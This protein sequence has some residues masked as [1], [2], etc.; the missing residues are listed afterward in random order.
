MLFREKGINLTLSYY[1]DGGF[2]RIKVI[3]LRKPTKY[4][5]SFVSLTTFETA[6]HKVSST[7]HMFYH[8]I[9]LYTWVLSVDVRLFCFYCVFIEYWSLC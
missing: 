1:S 5:L 2:V 9:T 4:P 7:S 8:G 3:Y 6:H